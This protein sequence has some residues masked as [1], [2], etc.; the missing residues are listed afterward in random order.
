MRLSGAQRC[1]CTNLGVRPTWRFQW[2]NHCRQLKADEDTPGYYNDGSTNLENDLLRLLDSLPDVR[3]YGTRN[4]T[5]AAVAAT[6]LLFDWVDGRPQGEA[7][8]WAADLVFP[9]IRADLDKVCRLSAPN[10]RLFLDLRTRD[11]PRG[12]CEWAC[13]ITCPTDRVGTV[14]HRAQ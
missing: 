3:M 6:E 8:A 14:S 11:F 1:A 10:V 4:T 12:P 2:F 9:H 5:D 7:T 13:H